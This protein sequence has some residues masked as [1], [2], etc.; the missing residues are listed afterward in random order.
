M[1]SGFYKVLLAS[2]AVTIGVGLL[3]WAY[4]YLLARL[5][6]KEVAPKPYVTLKPAS[7][8]DENQRVNFTIMVPETLD[9][10]LSI[11]ADNGD[12]VKR[13][14]NKELKKGNH[15][16]EWKWDEVPKNKL[17]CQLVTDYQKTE[18]IVPLT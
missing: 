1:S 3:F 16:F 5:N 2:L 12:I 14:C 9:V 10:S 11:V 7:V 13:L 4:R 6:K 15:K 17:F 8:D 18:K